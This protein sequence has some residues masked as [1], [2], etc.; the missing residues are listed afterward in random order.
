MSWKLQEALQ[1]AESHFHALLGAAGASRGYAENL[2]VGPAAYLGGTIRLEK[3]SSVL[4]PTIVSLLR[5]GAVKRFFRIVQDVSEFGPMSNTI[6]RMK[7]Q[8]VRQHSPESSV[9]DSL[10][11]FSRYS[12][13]SL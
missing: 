1:H 2:L 10:C 13:S 8:P 9:N 5:A 7:D 11:V 12:I 6:F 4:S 3:S